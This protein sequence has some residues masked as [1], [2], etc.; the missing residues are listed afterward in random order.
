M[1]RY[2]ALLYACRMKAECAWRDS[3]GYLVQ[4]DRLDAELVA[5]EEDMQRLQ[6]HLIKDVET[7][8]AA[9]PLRK[10][11]TCFEALLS[12]EMVSLEVLSWAEQSCYCS[13][14]SEETLESEMVAR[15]SEERR[16]GKECVSTCRSGWSPSHSTK[17]GVRIV[18]QLIQHRN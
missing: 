18:E 11:C 7:S 1:L 4:L 6:R 3:T 10:A 16:V 2:S 8:L 12:D 9:E 5:I 14:R 13:V 17:T 15:R